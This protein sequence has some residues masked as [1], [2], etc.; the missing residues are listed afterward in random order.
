MK[1]R[2]ITF[3]TDTIGAILEGRKTQ[4]RRVIKPQPDDDGG[5]DGCNTVYDHN[6]G[7][8][9]PHGQVGDHLWCRET[10][11]LSLEGKDIPP[12]YNRLFLYKA[13]SDLRLI[14]PSHYEWFDLKE[15]RGYG[16][17][18]S[19]H[20]PRWAARITLEITDIRAQRLQQINLED[21]KAEGIAGYTFARG[22]LS[23]N[24]PDPRWRFIEL[25]DSINAKR[26]YGWASNAWVWVI[27]FKGVSADVVCDN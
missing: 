18:P 20:M 16:W 25:W 10:W 9:C 27:S 15:K 13:G 1:E 11:A 23:N 8:F 22:C 5:I 17:R 3:S 7:E 6:I 14:D 12:H 2:P 4:T 26:G 21:V 24:P 19:I